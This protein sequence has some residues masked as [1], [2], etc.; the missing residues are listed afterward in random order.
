MSGGGAG[1]A[2]GG[3]GFSFAIFR[4]GC[5]RSRARV[6]VC[7]A[8]SGH[9]FLLVA[10]RLPLCLS[11]NILLLLLIHL[12]VHL[13]ISF[14]CTYFYHTHYPQLVSAGRPPGLASKKK[15]KT[16]LDQYM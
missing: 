13:S 1:G 2:G 3:V 10:T 12:L 8:Y 11:I 14:S 7:D 15:K 5:N 4:G 9:A 6:V 16:Y